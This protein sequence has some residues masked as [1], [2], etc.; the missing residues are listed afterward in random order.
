[1]KRVKVSH[2]LIRPLIADELYFETFTEIKFFDCFPVHWNEDFRRT[3]IFP[4]LDII[5]SSE[6]EMQDFLNGAI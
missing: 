6:P 1:M 2:K 4:G 5:H 3:I